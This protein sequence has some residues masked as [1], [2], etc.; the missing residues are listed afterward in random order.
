[1]TGGLLGWAILALLTSVATLDALGIAMRAR[2]SGRAELALVATA[3]WF[4]LLATPVLVLGYTNVLTPG[5]L[6]AASSSLLGGT[7]LVLARG[8]GG[9]EVVREGLQAARA[10]AGMPVDALRE[11]ARARSIVLL[12]CLVCAGILAVALFQT[13]FGANESWDGFLYHE[14]IIGFAIQ[15]HGFSIVPLQMH[16]AVQATNGYPHLCE[17]VS[18]W[19]V[20]FTDKTLIEMPNDIGGPAMM[21]AVYVLARRF[22]DRVTAMGWACVL[23]LMPQ[24]WTQLCGT[25]IDMAVAFF[26]LF[27]FH[28]A[29]RPALRISDALLAM[30]GMA[31]VLESKSS[32]L[33]IVPPIALLLAVRLVAGPRRSRPR[34]TLAVLV[35]GGVLLA[36]LALLVPLRNWEAFRDPL[37]PVSFDSRALG[38]H[39]DG[40][41]TPKDLGPIVPLREVVEHAYDHPSGGVEDAMQRGYGYAI[42][43]V[44]VPPGLVAV[45]GGLGTA[46]L[47]KLH[48]KESSSASN[49]GLLL[50]LVVTGILTTLTLNGQ[51]AR[52]NI[53]LVAGLLIAVT[54][55][56][57][58]RRW[59]ALRESVLGAS[60]LLSILPLFWM[61]GLL[62][63]W[64]STDH[65]EDMV[66]HPL[67]SRTAFARPTLD[68]LARQRNEELRAGD[69]AVFD[70]DVTFVGA[71]WN[72]DFSNRVK[73]VK[74]EG[75]QQ[76]LLAVEEVAPKWVAV[77]KGGDSRK[78]LERSSRW[79][80][81]GEIFREGDV[82]FR[83]KGSRTA[84]QDSTRVRTA[85]PGS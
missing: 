55:L 51:N 66:H 16:Q 69:W 1:M 48:W 32:G 33:V 73:Y 53:H 72:F 17:A 79:E 60:I 56:L 80:L 37:W 45:V 22:G 43:W 57:A 24:C 3:A 2:V 31:L 74:Y 41:I 35:G 36:G 9:R 7:F 71:L 50:L 77:G 40:L 34:A 83:R 18:L 76:W 70:Q 61:N 26:A 42:A 59:A 82:V 47:E 46:L 64:T 5:A 65:P 78:A 6:I 20:V 11:A 28:F 30:L 44:V 15:N 62:W 81:V 75:S 4:A 29:T 52:Y 58:R 14:P 54:W 21:L 49:L 38:I 19:L 12:G 84:D 13:V 68:Q 25:M 39:W 63:P 27:A 67:E 23:L 10:I 85:T 8:R